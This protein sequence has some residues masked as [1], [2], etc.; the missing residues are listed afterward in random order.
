M[1]IVVATDSFKGSMRSDEAGSIIADGIRESLRDA[2]IEV[3][4]IA[5]GGEGTTDAVIRATGGEIKQVAVTGPLGEQTT[6][7]YGL[8]PDGQTAIMEMASASGIELVPVDRLDPMKATTYGTGELIR[9]AIED[10][11]RDIILGIGGSATVDGGTGMAQALGY[12]LLTADGSECRRG[13]EALATITAIE[14]EGVLPALADCRIRVACDVT[15]PLL[16]DLG[17]ARVFGPQKGATPKMV[18]LLETGLAKLGETWVRE[19]LLTDVSSP[20]DGAAGGLGAGLRAFCGAEMVSG[21]DL[22]AEITGFD[23][24]IRDADIL[25]TGE[26]RT[27]EQTADGKLCAVLAEKARHAGASTILLSGALAGD[28]EDLGGLF[29]AVFAAVQDVCS[30]EDAIERGPENLSTTA[31]NIGRILALGRDLMEAE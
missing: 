12:R 21:A 9:S 11:V 24:E 26:G 28:L 5:D 30:L 25:V 3:I 1:K 17:A 19:G 15:N 29:D 13:G 18:E 14:S 22:V 8:L 10:G 7:R 31:K 20:G 23:D 6:A 16:G 4:P 27:D 2:E